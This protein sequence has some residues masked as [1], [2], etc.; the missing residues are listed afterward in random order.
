MWKMNSVRNKERERR[1]MR[2]K[3]RR[4]TEDLKEHLIHRKWTEPHKASFL[5]ELAAVGGAAVEKALLIWIKLGLLCNIPLLWGSQVSRPILFFLWEVSICSISLRSLLT[6]S[7]TD[8]CRLAGTALAFLFCSPI[9]KSREKAL[10]CCLNHRLVQ[11]IQWQCQWLIIEAGDLTTVFL[12]RSNGCSKASFL[13]HRCHRDV[14]RY[15][16]IFHFFH[17]SDWLNKFVWGCTNNNF[18][19][20]QIQ[21]RNAIKVFEVTTYM[22][23][24]IYI[25]GSKKY[26]SAGNKVIRA[27]KT[28]LL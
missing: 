24:N 15:Q 20:F 13:C 25:K 4:D 3:Q 12:R 1:K 28:F 2:K 21:N 10:P 19:L 5:C 27:K 16:V 6:C 9:R 22:S 11:G 8:L 17:R 18:I 26:F 23:M 14:S 7:V